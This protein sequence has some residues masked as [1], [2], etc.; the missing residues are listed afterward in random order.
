MPENTDQ[1]NSEYGHFSHSANLYFLG[2]IYWENTQRCIN[3]LNTEHKKIRR[4]HESTEFQDECQEINEE[5]L[6]EMLSN[7]KLKKV[8]KVARS[9]NVSTVGRKT[10]IIMR[11]KAAIVTEEGVTHVN[12]VFP[13]AWSCVLR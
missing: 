10:Y 8:K 2:T 12:D 5:R 13:S 1:K 9:C 11:I 4:V 7:D 6:L 3:V